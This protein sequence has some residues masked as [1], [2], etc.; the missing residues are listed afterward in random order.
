[1]RIIWVLYF[2]FVSDLGFRGWDF[3]SLVVRSDLDDGGLSGVEHSDAATVELEDQAVLGVHADAVAGEAFA[4][5]RQSD[6]LAQL[7]AEVAPGLDDLLFAPFG[8]TEPVVQGGEDPP[9]D[10]DTPALGAACHVEAGGNCLQIRREA[11]AGLM[12]VDADPDDVDAGG[13]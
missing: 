6:P 5:V 12:A 3:L 7:S 2:G 4:V 8:C 1:M 13:W 10:G 11:V 9:G